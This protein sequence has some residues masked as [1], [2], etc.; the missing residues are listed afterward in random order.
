[1]FVLPPRL[2]EGF[3]Y[4]EN[5]ISE[6]EKANLVR[7]FDALPFKPFEFHGN[8]GN[9]RIVSF[10]WQYDYA[11]QA[12]RTAKLYRI[13]WSRYGEVPHVL[14]ALKLRRC[15]RRSSQNTRRV[16]VSVG[17]AISQCSKMCWH[18]HSCRPVACAFGEN[19]MTRGNVR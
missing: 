4:R 9:R 15:S 7:V 12:L 18:F 6:N 5:V 13:S 1:L 17:I 19:R 10:G 14:P 8:L 3:S 2:P 16:Q 11:K